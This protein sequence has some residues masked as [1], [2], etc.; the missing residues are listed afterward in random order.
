MDR[1]DVVVGFRPA[2]GAARLKRAAWPMAEA[3]GWFAYRAKEALKS[4]WLRREDVR[5]MFEDGESRLQER[6]LEAVLVL[7]NDNHDHGMLQ[8]SAK[9]PMYLRVPL[10]LP[11]STRG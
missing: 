1:L 8:Q 9:E 4:N 11:V 6:G 2:W 7:G 5:G 3:L 10:V